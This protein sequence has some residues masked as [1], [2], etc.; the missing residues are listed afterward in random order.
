MSD[1]SLNASTR[2]NLLALQKNTAS[3]DRTSL[4]LS[5]G[6]R[7][8]A[9]TDNVR[10]LI[11]AKALTDRAGDLLSIKE[12]IGQS[13]STVGGALDGLKAI[14]RLV[15]QL[16]A[17]ANDATN[18]TAAG[19]AEQAARFDSIRAQLDSIA[20]DANFNGIGLIASSP[21]SLTVTFDK[22]NGS[23]LTISGV[24]SDTKALGIGDGAVA[25]N[26]FATDADIQAAI[27]ALDNAVTTLR[28]T[29]SQLGNNA[30]VLN[31]RLD[32]TQ[33]LANSLATGADKL[34]GADLNEEAASLLALNVARSLS[35][36][37]L[38]ITNK[39]QQSVLQL[40]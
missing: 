13:L 26:N 15:E 25:F 38:N 33:D 32:F 19:R 17:T 7:V 23:S 29:E 5:T 9:A 12:P 2:T 18:Q 39:S 40:F 37:S 24:A 20:R 11:L 3:I 27:D 14:K 31:T 21:D 34:T 36:N 1:I 35:I 22:T 28:S 8:N 10:A 16:K 4:R 6:K 30:G